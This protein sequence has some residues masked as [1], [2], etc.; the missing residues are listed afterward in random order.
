MNWT[1]MFWG[2]AGIAVLAV[3]M[4]LRHLQA[5]FHA[6]L[7]AERDPL[8]DHPGSKLYRQ[9]FQGWLFAIGDGSVGWS[10]RVLTVLAALVILGLVAWS[11]LPEVL[12]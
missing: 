9:R 8:A 2:L 10:S 11:L 5:R 4:W 3:G 1:V 12:S 7:V 6:G